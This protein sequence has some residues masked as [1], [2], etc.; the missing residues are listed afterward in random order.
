MK[1]TYLLLFTTI[2]FF[3]ACKQEEKKQL[4]IYGWNILTDHTPTALHTLE[5]SANYKVNQLQLSYDICHELRDVKHQWNRNIVNNLTE[6]AHETGINEVLVWDHALYDLKYYPE[7]FTI[8][9][10]INLDKR[11]FWEWIIEDYEK[12]LNK[13]PDIDGI[14]L[15]LNDTETKIENQHSEVLN[16]PEEKLATFVDSLA[17]LIVEQRNLKLYLR[18]PVHSE[19]EVET[20]LSF[21]EQIKTPG[22]KFIANSLPGDFLINQQYSAWVE[23]IPIPVLIDFDCVHVNEG[24]GIVAS[25]FTDLHLKLWKS[26]QA[27]PNVVGFSLRTDRLGKSSILGRP[28]EIN[29]FTVY[30]ALQNPEI[31]TDSVI[32]NFLYKNYDSLAVPYFYDAFKLAPEIIMSSFYTLGINTSEQSEINFSYQPSFIHKITLGE[33]EDARIEIGHGVNQS[34]HYWSDIVNH[35]APAEYK[36]PENGILS[37]L[38]EV[39]AGNWLQPEERID[40]TY[41]NYILTEKKYAINQAFEAI[42]KVNMAKP[43]C[44]NSRTFNRI[45]HTFNRTLLT[46]KLRKAYAQVYYANRIWNRGEEFQN[47]KLAS[48]IKDGVTEIQ[49]T[50]EDIKRYRRKGPTGQYNWAEDAETAMNLVQKIKNSDIWQDISEEL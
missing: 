23:K 18:Y 20:L 37:S 49:I 19:K 3:F 32:L 17:G 30:A 13:I 41:L 42:S 44:K 2:L 27:M 33:S 14:V 48:L 38:Q 6:K 7:R 10:K 40:T 22:I 47:E 34:F 12:M 24:Q 46:A 39:E 1:Q 28:S 11:D 36:N 16:T 45:Y 31:E 5:A 4:E 9:G 50:S 26:Y 15:T 29:L 8:N 35:L 25:V 43:Y 21:L